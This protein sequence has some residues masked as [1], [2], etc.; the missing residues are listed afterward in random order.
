MVPAILPYL[1]GGAAPWPAKLSSHYHFSECII[2]HRVHFVVQRAT[3]VD[4]ASLPHYNARCAFFKEQ[5]ESLFPRSTSNASQGLRLRVPGCC[6]TP[7]VRCLLRNTTPC[8]YRRSSS[9]R[10][11]VE[12]CL[13]KWM[14]YKRS[15]GSSPKVSCD[16]VLS[17]EQ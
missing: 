4:S 17:P 10:K 9:A 6:R 13:T 7:Y 15:L 11:G 5:E 2:I 8:K 3:C 14:Y 1:T 16:S 12:T